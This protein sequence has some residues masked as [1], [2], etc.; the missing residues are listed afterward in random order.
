[1]DHEKVKVQINTVVHYINK[2]KRQLL[3][4]HT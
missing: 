4:Q 3:L 1:M 2:L